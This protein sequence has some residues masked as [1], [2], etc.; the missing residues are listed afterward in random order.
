[1]NAEAN[2]PNDSGDSGANIKEFAGKVKDVTQSFGRVVVRLLG[3]YA[4]CYSNA[5]YHDD[6]AVK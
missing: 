2:S 6:V 5:A 3:C 4:D 1:M